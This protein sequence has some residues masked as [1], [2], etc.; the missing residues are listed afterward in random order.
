MAVLAE[1][2]ILSLSSIFPLLVSYFYIISS[3]FLIYNSISSPIF[4]QG[5]LN[6]FPKRI[7]GKKFGNTY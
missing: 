4:L 7:P 3:F 2:L 1:V 5:H 6:L